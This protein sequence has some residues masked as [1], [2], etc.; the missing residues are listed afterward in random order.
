MGSFIHSRECVLCAIRNRKVNPLQ[1]SVVDLQHWVLCINH[2]EDL[3]FTGGEESCELF[4]KCV[5]LSGL[6]ED[7]DDDVVV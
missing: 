5:S 4:E 7:A 1:L 2:R 3:S 6:F